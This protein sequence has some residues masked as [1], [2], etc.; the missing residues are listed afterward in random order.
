M[1]KLIT[2]VLVAASISGLCQKRS[3]RIFDEPI[4][5]DTLSTLFIPIRYNEQILSHNKIAFWG[6]YYA[7]IIVYNF[8]TDSSKKLF[9]SDT[10]IKSLR[11]NYSY[12]TRDNEKIRNLCS[13]WVF[14]LVKP[15]DTNGNGRIDENDPSVLM[16]VSTDGQTI[17][18]LTEATEDVVEII[19]FEKQGF[20][21][22]KIQR[23][24]DGKSSFGHD[25][26]ECYFKKINLTDLTSGKTIDAN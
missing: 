3:A 16:S 17:K 19:P 6:D 18:Q 10:Y 25:N 8:K 22:I 7:N 1:K 4:L 26:K 23:D 15:N 2:L 24:V 14:V 9:P 12:T 21:L 11:A 13:K 5:T 20:V